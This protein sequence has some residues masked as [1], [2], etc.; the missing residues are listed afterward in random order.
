MEV[1]DP[2]GGGHFQGQLG[3]FQWEEA[4]RTRDP[5]EFVI[6][7]VDILQQVMEDL[8]RTLAT[9]DDGNAGLLL[10]RWLVVQKGAGV[11]DARV[12]RVAAIGNIGAG[13]GAEDQLSGQQ[14]GHTAR[15]AHCHAVRLSTFVVTDV[16]HFAVKTE[17]VEL[18]AGPLAVLVV[19]AAQQEKI[20]ADIE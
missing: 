10:Q 11:Q 2:L 7:A 13:A 8:R 3:V 5:V 18:P 12:V 17:V 20:L 19:F 1:V 9:A 15:V 4:W 14:A 16:G 6:T